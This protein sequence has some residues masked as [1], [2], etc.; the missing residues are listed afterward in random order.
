MKD[1]HDHY[2]PNM[3]KQRFADMSGERT[4]IQTFYG[5]CFDYAQAAWDDIK[6]YQGVYIGFF[7][8]GISINSF[9]VEDSHGAEN[10]S[11]SIDSGD[12]ERFPL[13]LQLDLLNKG[14]D[15]SVLFGMD[16]GVQFGGKFTIYGGGGL[17]FTSCRTVFQD[18]FGVFNEAEFAWKVNGGARLLFSGA[19]VR[20]DISYSN[21]HGF[22]YGV[23]FGFGIK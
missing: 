1:P 8:A 15:H 5:I 6:R 12:G 9:K 18:G 19:S 21:N 16:M 7:S 23:L 22:L 14:G 11:F 2:T 20:W 10:F 3:M 17:G 4:R 13:F